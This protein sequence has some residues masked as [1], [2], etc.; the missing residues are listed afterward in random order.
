MAEKPNIESH[1]EK[2]QSDVD[3]NVAD[4]AS[5][6]ASVTGISIK[7]VR[8]ST[9]AE[10]QIK[11]EKAQKCLENAA[12]VSKRIKE[13]RKAAAELLGKP[14]DDDEADNQSELASAVSEKTNYSV[15]TDSSAT[16]SVQDAL[17][18]PGISE[19]LAN[20]LKQ[21]EL[22]MERIKQY[23]E[24]SKRPMK[25]KLHVKKELESVELKKSSDSSELSKVM[26]IVKEKENALSVMQVKL[27]AMETTILDLQEKINE[28]DQIIEAK[29][30]ATAIISDSMTK[31]EKESLSVLD[32]TKQ[33][34]VK[35][36]NNFIN[37]ESEW[38]KQKSK[39]EAEINEKNDKIK[40]L[41]EANTILEN[42]RFEISIAHSKL[43]EEL[44][45][46]IEKIKQ[47]EEKLSSISE[48]QSFGH[49]KEHY[50]EEKG[51]KEI[52][53]MEEL[54]KKLDLLEQL[55]YE[56]R[57]SNKELQNQISILSND[58]KSTAASTVSSPSKKGSPLPSR[59]GARNT[60]SKLKSPWSRLSTESL[61][62]EI[63]KKTVKTDNTKAE[64]LLQALNKDII[65]KEYIISEKDILITE[66]KGLIESKEVII[67]DL[68]LVNSQKQETINK[69]D[70]GV[71]TELIELKESI[72]VSHYE[73]DST[74]VNELHE[75]LKSAH[76]Q[77]ISLNEEIDTANRNMIKVKSNSKLQLK[78]MQKTIENFSK[79]SDANA[80]IVRLNEEI[81]HLTQKVAELEEEKGNL[82]LHLVDYDSG[83]Y[84]HQLQQKNA[85]MEDKLAD[86]TQLQNEQ[87]CSEMKSVQ[88]EEEIDQLSASKS[89]L[90][91]VVQN[92]KL[93]VERH[94][95]TIKTLQ[96]EKE[97]LVLK[98]ENFIQENIDLTDK[99]EKLSTEK[100]SSAESIEIVESLTTQERLE[101]EEYNKNS[102]SEKE[103]REGVC[104]QSIS[105]DTKTHTQKQ[106]VDEVVQ[107]SAELRQKIDLF[108]QEREEVMEKMNSLCSEN[109]ALNNCIEELRNK[110][111]TLQT[112]IDTLIEEKEK[113]LSLNNE[114]KVHIEELKRE[115]NDIIKEPIEVPKQLLTDDVVDGSQS[116]VQHDDRSSTEKGAKGLKSMKQMTKEI[117]KLKNIIKEREDEIA[118]CQMKILSLEEQQQKQNELVQT[119]LLNENKIKHLLEENSNLKKQNEAIVSS[120]KKED[121]VEYQEINEKLKMELQQ[122]QQ[123]YSAALSTHDSKIQDLEQLLK[124]YEKQIFNYNNTLQQKDKEITDYINQITKLNDLSHKLKSTME[125]LEQE[126][127][128]D[129][130]GEVVKSL[131]QQIALYQNALADCEEKIRVFEEEKVQILSL[132]TK[133]ENRNTILENELAK[134]TETLNE[135]LNLIKEL[136]AQTQKY[137]DEYEK[138][139]KEAKDKDEEIHEIKLQ[140]R[141]ESIENEKLR[142]SLQE[143]ENLVLEINKQYEDAKEKLEVTFKDKGDY[144]ALENKNKEL[145]EK[146]K[147]F[148]ANIKK[149]TVMYSD[150]EKQ[151]NDL[152]SQLEL[153]NEKYEEAIIQ[154]EAIPALQEK[155]KFADQELNRL[156]TERSL[157]NNSLHDVEEQLT[158]LQNKY[159]TLE[160]EIVSYKESVKALN[161]VILLANDEK[162]LLVFNIESL[163]NKLAQTELEQR[164]NAN[165]L[166]KISC[167]ESDLVE[168]QQ[169]ISELT[170]QMQCQE[171]NFNQLQYSHDAKVQERDMY[172]ENLQIENEKYKNRICR[173][174][175]S[176]SIMENRRQS[177]ERKADQLDTLLQDKQKAYN[178]YTTQEDELI[179]RL[180]VLMDHDRVVEKQLQ[181]IEKDNKDLIIKIQ[182]LNEELQNLGT[183]YAEL[184]HHS[185]NLEMKVA[186]L[187]DLEAEAL[188]YRASSENQET[189][190]KKLSIEHQN[191]LSLKK[192]EIDDLESEFNTQIEETVK[193]KK[194]LGE[195]YEKLCDHVSK[196]ELE[197]QGYRSAIEDLQLQIQEVSLENKNLIQNSTLTREALPDYTEQ[198]ISEIN[199]LNALV[200]QKSLEINNYQNKLEDLLSNNDSL[201]A[202]L[203]GKINELSSKLNESLQRL[204]EM[205]KEYESTS[206]KNIELNNLLTQKEDQ[207]KQLIEKKKVMFEMN[208]PKTEGMMITSTIEELGD[209]QKMQDIEYLQSQI[210]FETDKPDKQLEPVLIRETRNVENQP[211]LH[212]TLGSET[213]IEPL[214]VPKQS[215][216]CYKGDVSENK[217]IDPFNSEEGWGLDEQEDT[218]YS[219]ITPGLTR[220]SQEIEQLKEVNVNLKKELELA[221]SKLMKAIKK[222]KELKSS[223]DMLSNELK[224]SKQISHSN[225]LDMAIESE[226]STNLQQ[227]E[228]KV[229]ELNDTLNREKKEKEALSKQNEVLKNGHD[230]LIE[231]KEKLDSELQLWKYKFKEA[232]DKISD[233]NISSFNKTSDEATI[234]KTTIKTD[235]QLQGDFEK[236]EKENDELQLALD[237]LNSKN[238]ELS[239]QVVKLEIQLKKVNADKFSIEEYN[240][241]RQQFEELQNNNSYLSNEFS[242]L[243]DQY[244]MLQSQHKDLCEYCENI[245]ADCM[246]QNDQNESLRQ[247][248]EVLRN[249]KESN[250]DLVK[251][252]QSEIERLK[253]EIINQSENS[254]SQLNVLSEKLRLYE[255][256][257]QEHIQNKNKVTEKN[258]ELEIK[259]EQLNFDNSSSQVNIMTEKIKQYEFEV[260]EYI[261]NEIQLTEKIKEL[262]I[263]VKQLNSENDQLLSN[264]TELQSS[265]SSA[266]DQRGFEIAE[267]WKQHLA[268]RES[269]FLKI[270]EDLRTQLSASESR[271]E[272]LLD[273][274]QSSTQ[275]ETNKIVMVEQVTS[276]QS[277]LQEKEEQLNSLKEKYADVINQLEM[278]RSDIEDE[279]VLNEEKLLTLQEEHE[280]II[281][282]LK[283]ENKML[284]EQ[285]CDINNNLQVELA[286]IKTVNDDLNQKIEKLTKDYDIKIVD[287]SKQ[288][289]IKESEIFHKTH[290]YTVMLADRNAEFENVRKQLLEYEKKVEELS[291]ERESEL[292]VL[293]LKMHEKTEH[294][295]SYVKE[296]LEEKEKLAEAVNAKIIECTTLNKQIED[297]NKILE[298]YVNKTAETQ[299]VLESQELEIVTLKDEIASIRELTRSPSSKIEKHVAFAPDTKES[300]NEG[301]EGVLN[302]ELL[303]GVP[304]AELDLA[305]Y[306]LHQRDVRCEELTMELTQLLEERD[307]LQLRLS[308]SLRSYE[309]LKLRYSG[310]DISAD[311][312]V[313]TVPEL[314]S[315]SIEKD[316]PI[317]DIHRGQTSRSSSISEPDGSDKPKLQA[318]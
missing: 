54:T 117:L 218:K 49:V 126:K 134:L 10:R 284:L 109:D 98:L 197:N 52:A 269:E 73:I 271:Y 212:S 240:S 31:K 204:E 77:I 250:S 132:K 50:K 103:E 176:I 286:A 78:Q 143:K 130:N 222:I 205:T 230:R 203:E 207:I 15:A 257:N 296:L 302:K 40:N 281:K 75:K 254:N 221:N 89:E 60:A 228:K 287:L 141:K 116:D 150:L 277:K 79:I 280:K 219:D 12:L 232:N 186:K 105:L 14:F 162:Q 234:L 88:L 174:E 209:E 3:F 167:L 246:L 314:P 4:S 227:L 45:L 108:T 245:K 56:M 274:V 156:Q 298:E 152:Q 107:E 260:Q 154:V 195:K 38:E 184:Q 80:E 137:K 190:L 1:S 223:N 182:H 28:K 11:F 233:I 147:K 53:D 253:I 295:E 74:D 255:V 71:C 124:E 266:M 20:T 166:T 85:E 61:N 279:K 146:L 198:Y 118:D 46:K 96:N 68:K 151:Y 237:S 259:L 41:Q 309:D 37:M 288:I 62:Q 112:N 164:N 188:S 25:I 149:R 200:N 268:Q 159:I 181:E 291:Y 272:Q 215:Y 299:M 9:T 263:K 93:D 310:A 293:R 191:L 158:S 292:A 243:T 214:I 161:E 82:Q 265:I 283:L 26:N 102:K 267:L 270:E 220:L 171:Q 97:E 32:D 192:K 33:Q 173:L 76:N 51:S 153:K 135:K 44:E 180:A 290:D 303:D 69:I 104:V 70:V 183:A 307:T 39:L 305:L 163:N 202:N 168:K 297:L 66:L 247:E 262:E 101:L 139:S 95:E 211:L 16:L 35:M 136:Q 241:L 55:N 22:L 47:L 21:K 119:N 27:K 100:V 142:I 7:N 193:E 224:I 317:V 276:L 304:R 106:S 239:D 92:L 138:V 244:N 17:N 248:I 229:H 282:D 84:L 157:L 308:D 231:M 115:R 90:E 278:L 140:L 208:I 196:L 94:V 169:Q 114:L 264:V 318:K 67:N 201:K 5:E 87:V 189:C 312:S 217:E 251:S 131:N 18:I 2:D 301:R 123:E 86:I 187:D 165:I 133:L 294:Y 8:L 24:I 178:E 29:N 63:E 235:S 129:H 273:N 64:M 206:V 194:V 121:Q 120:Y 236:L 83:R 58:N 275:E 148:A 72:P 145:L 285:Q 213:L 311:S 144:L 113:A 128:N 65:E 226:L 30:K 42:A 225:I 43:V 99:L 19:S 261:K 238:K 36:Q 172:I 179:C 177:L 258:K 306:M 160:D 13:H 170:K 256:E 59:K 155:L 34:M 6:V 125:L 316:H 110:C 216:L 242:K 185:N 210:V 122:I 252:L 313:D 127:A 249:E 111:L 91:F 315:F 175:E 199:R 48:M 289:Q 57:T 300:A 23:K 81:H